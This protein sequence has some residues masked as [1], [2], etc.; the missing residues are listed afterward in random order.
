MPDRAGRGEEEGR[1]ERYRL[2]C[3]QCNQG[4]ETVTTIDAAGTV[5]VPTH[6]MPGAASE[7]GRWGC[8]GGRRRVGPVAYEAGAEAFQGTAA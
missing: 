8:M 3:P 6:A 1:T 2:R 5:A 7:G 4:F